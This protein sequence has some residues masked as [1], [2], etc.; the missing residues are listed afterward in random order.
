MTIII[1][2]SFFIANA[3]AIIVDFSTDTT[4]GPTPLTVQFTD[5]SS[6]TPTGWAWYFGDETYTAPWVLQTAS[7]GWK[8]RIHHNSVVMPD[9][10]IVL[11]GGYGIEPFSDVWRSTDSGTTWSNITTSAGC[12][13]R[14]GHS[15]VVM[16]DGSI[17][18]MGGVKGGE[19][20]KNDTWRSTDNGATWIQ[21]TE[22]S[23][24]S[25][26]YWHSSV[27]MPDGSIVL[28]G[29]WEYDKGC[30]NDVWR[31]TDYGATWTEMTASAGWSK[32]QYHS[33]V[34]MAD[35][36]II[37]IGG[38]ES[39]GAIKD[40]LWR[41]TDYGATW[42]VVE[43]NTGMPVGPYPS[44][45]VMPDDSIVVMGDYRDNSD[46]NS[47][48]RSTD[49]GATWTKIDENPGWSKRYG[50]R[51]VVIPDGSIVLI[52][53]LGMN[54]TWRFMSAGSSAQNPS[55]TYTTPGTYP[56]ALQAYNASGYNSTRKTGF[57][58]VTIPLPVANFTGTP[59]SGQA[60]LTV[61]FTDSSANNPTSWNWLFGDG[62]QE[63]ATEQNPVHTYA[64]AGTYTVS[65]NAT[66]AGGSNIK[67][68]AGY[69][70]VNPTIPVADF[71]GTPTSGPAP[72]TVQFT[73]ASTNSPTGWAWYFGD[74]NYTGPW[75]E[76]NASSG[77]LPRF[78]HSTVA[79]PDGSIVLMG[80]DDA[81]PYK[82]DVWRSTDNGATWTQMT[83]NAGWS[84]RFAHRS[85]VMPDSSILLM[86]GAD[87]YLRNDVWR[88]TD[89]GTTWILMTPSAE[90]SARY[91]HSSIVMSDGSIVLMGGQNLSM[92]S[93]MNDVWRSTDNG[94]TWTQI[95]ASA[96]W[97]ERASPSCVV[98][99][100]DSI[101]LMGGAVPN[102]YKND[103]WRS[104]DNGATWTQMTANAGWSVRSGSSSVA[105]P[106]GSIVLMGG[107]NDT[108][109]KMN[110]VWR[111]TDNGATWT[112]LPNAGWSARTSPSSVVMPD[113]SIVLTGGSTDTSSS[114]S[115][116]FKNDTWRFMPTGS[117][118]QNPSHTYAM[119]GTYPV[120]LQVFN[121]DG[122]NSTRKIGYITVA[123]P[124]V[125]SFNATPS[126]G[127]APLTV[128]F[129]DTSPSSNLISWTWAFG[130]GAT[131]T[132]QNISHT[133]ANS[134]YYSTSLTILDSFGSSNTTSKEITVIAVSDNSTF[135]INGTETSAGIITINTRLTTSNGTV[136]TLSDNDTVITLTNLDANGWESLVIT[137]DGV[138]HSTPDIMSGHI[139]G[140]VATTKPVI[141]D[142]GGDIGNVE[143]SIVLRLD[144]MPEPG[145]KLL[146][147]L[148][149]NSSQE[150]RN[151]FQ[152]AALNNHLTI[153]EIAYIVNLLKE[154]FLYS[155]PA[156]IKMAINADWVIT[157]IG[158]NPATIADKGAYLLAHKTEV[159]Q[160]V[161]I[162]RTADNGSTEILTTHY[163][164]YSDPKAFYQADSPNG[165]STFGFTSVGS[166]STPDSGSD[167][168]PGTDGST[169][170]ISTSGVTVTEI[171][172]VGGGSA[173]TRAEMTGTGLGK[174]LVITAMPRSNLPTS[175]SP[176]P[177]TVFQ[178]LS[179]TSSTITGVISQ[180]TFDFSVPQSWLTEHGFT[181][182]DIV[183]MRNVDGQ[184]QTLD[185]QFVSEKGGYAFYHSTA[186]GLS[187]FAIAFQNGGTDMGTSTL[188]PT[189]LT[190]VGASA[191]DAPL[192]VSL[193]PKE[194]Q[195]LSP[196]PVSSTVEGKPVMTIIF[197]IIGIIAIIIG[198]FLVRRWW[199]RRQ[200]PALFRE[201]N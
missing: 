93:L 21:V 122:F 5:L 69:I 98:M 88:S 34:V 13:P 73:D 149:K 55:H 107:V 81:S 28:M 38:E 64:S 123:S 60:P 113:G 128:Q 99:P 19:G 33:S 148:V 160:K 106:E 77:W 100:D 138:S 15:S 192:P 29:G 166:I 120:V 187:Y 174:N 54:D 43:T 58:T 161:R 185:T 10:S 115:K 48:G 110:D 198:A 80:G 130:D 178:Y 139:T 94:T 96:G 83:A 177:T 53:G 14:Y 132:L 45:V 39:S 91:Y 35:S 186:T 126:S 95:T 142:L 188:S 162:F 195:T 156:T 52:S 119:P 200:N 85:V 170:F 104:T 65:L 118:I 37:L 27:V 3:A 194:T 41:S 179:I 90:W 131:S 7:A 191:I 23:G 17:V 135:D 143:L 86:G 92:P 44:S 71:T 50:Q 74:E 32:R 127:I 82:N 97:S 66:N 152:Q 189:T 103:V 62:S 144:T 163:M 197:G 173:V 158:G 117:S 165:L 155:N 67:I 105:T 75:T 30:M 11:I 184:W 146:Q 109:S 116:N 136:V 125:A 16:P 196:A 102:A 78:V 164:S 134:G 6:N 46:M 42:T 79:M 4:Y 76:V 199:I 25:P 193:T 18:L 167:S 1:G 175:I 87:A 190:T 180:I 112:Q 140:I 49:Y 151:A 12:L 51:S 114:N 154:N 181:S 24:W 153:K 137:T 201:N 56:V 111:S 182:G 171:V 121:A 59:I 22:S 9:G 2:I 145:A 40:D 84:P 26:R 68:S 133:Y 168:D 157:Q 63:N 61:A 183:M 72:L 101:V 124:P 150:I 108:I 159:E 36:S 129:N 169:S 89:N 176:P 8:A 70:T 141:A 47:V 172:N 20:L 57:I 31:S 147:D